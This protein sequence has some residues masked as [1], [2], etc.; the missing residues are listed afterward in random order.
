MI[1]AGFPGPFIGRDDERRGNLQ[2]FY[3]LASVLLA[4]DAAWI[5]ICED[6]VTWQANA[7]AIICAGIPPIPTLDNFG[8]LSFHCTRKVSRAIE[9]ANGRKG[10][11]LPAGIYESHAGSETWGAQ[12][13]LFSHESLTMLVNTV[14]FR[15]RVRTQR[16]GLDSTIFGVLKDLYLRAWYLL[17]CLARHDL[18][19]H[20]SGILEVRYDLGESPHTLRGCDY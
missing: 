9:T 2:N 6:D 18:G 16:T 19:E 15:D 3:G 4:S 20:N 10:F 13:L 8:V 17:P 14:T 11:R 7:Y 1:D 5:L 12:A